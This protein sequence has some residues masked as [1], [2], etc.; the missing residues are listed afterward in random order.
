[1]PYTQMKS[2]P[3]FLP[4]AL[5]SSQ[6]GTWQIDFDRDHA[7]CDTTTAALF[8]VDPDE[9]SIGL[10]LTSFARAIHPDDRSTYD[11]RTKR[12][13][14]HGGLYVVEYRTV[15]RPGDVR[16][17]LVRGRYDRDRLTGNILGRGIVI[18]ITESKFDGIVED[19]AYF[20]APDLPEIETPL[21]RAAG[22]ALKAKEA[23]DEYVGRDAAV[24]G[25]AI[26]VVL[27][28]IGC[29]LARQSEPHIH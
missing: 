17:I 28:I 13:R 22:Y 20:L 12:M 6:V 26:N 15:P 16:W 29:A 11:D 1:M 18:D 21:E 5:I 8:G 4:D 27:W 14:E 19:N 25:R 7:V 10:S 2:V 3:A 23:V 24:L 9:A